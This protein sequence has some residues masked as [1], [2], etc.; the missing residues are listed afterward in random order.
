MFKLELYLLIWPVHPL[1]YMPDINRFNRHLSS[2]KYGT[3][4]GS[5]VD[6]QKLFTGL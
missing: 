5:G 3:R 4:I 2:Y 6:S 1:I